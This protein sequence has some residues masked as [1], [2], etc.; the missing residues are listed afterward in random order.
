MRLNYMDTFR[1]YLKFNEWSANACQWYAY[2]Y[3]YCG[4]GS[5][6]IYVSPLYDV[7]DELYVYRR[8]LSVTEI[9]TLANS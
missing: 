3:G 4:Q 6:T 5:N 7:I 8:E 1:F 2:P 9:N